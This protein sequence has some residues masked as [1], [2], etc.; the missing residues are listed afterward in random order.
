MNA[1]LFFCTEF[2]NE[3]GMKKAR[4]AELLCKSNF[5]FLRGASHPHELINEAAA[6]GYT[7]L[8]LNDIGG[9]Y[10]IPKAFQAQRAHSQL[11]LITGAE[12]PMAEGPA[13]TLLAQDRAGY[14]RLCR[15]ITRAHQDRPKG[16]ALLNTKS[17][18]SFANEHGLNGLFLIARP[19]D[20]SLDS[21][22]LLALYH[23]LFK[24]RVAIPLSRFFDGQDRE[25]HEQA[26]AQQKKFGWP[27]FA[28][29]DAHFHSS[30]RSRLQDVLTSI[31]EGIP[32]REA[33]FKL[34]MNAE[35]QLKSPAQMARI[36]S[37]FPESIE[38][39]LR[40]AETCTFSPAELR[41]R[42]P[43]EWIPT[44]HT[45]QSYLEQESRRGIKDLYANEVPADV[46]KQLNFELN[47][48][49]E[50]GFAD[51]FLS[52]YDIVCF[53]RTRQILCQG[54][55]SAANSVVCYALGITAID[56]VRMS[57]LFERFISVERGEPPD[58]DV[59]FEHERREEVIQYIYEKYGRDRAAMVSA[60]IT[61]RRRSAFREA[62]KALG[63]N[64]G[65]HSARSVEKNFAVLCPH[66]PTRELVTNLADEM[67]TFPRHLS[68][69]SGGFT[70]SA[71]PIIETV[72]VEP[73]AMQGRSIV[74]WDKYDL[75]ILGLLKIDVLALGML[76]ALRKTLDLTQKKLTDIPAD[77]PA[78]YAMIQKADT[79]GVFQI[80]SRAQ[81]NMLPRLLPKNFY[82][83]VIQV[84]IVRPGP[85]V[86]KMVHPYL[87]RRKGLEDAT[88]PDSRLEPILGRTLG[89][90]IFQEQI[91]KMAIHLGGFTPGEADQLRRAIG[92]WR[93]AGSIDEAGQRLRN[94]LLKNG[95]PADF[96]DRIFL[97]I[98]GFSEYGFPESHAA[99]FALLA[100]ASSYL[101]CHHPAEFACSLI[102][103]QPMGF[104]S[105]HSI[106]D[107]AK[108]HGVRT[109]AVNVNRSE[110]D[111]TIEAPN[112]I[113]LGLR[114]V[115][116]M[117]S[118]EAEKI[119]RARREKSF[120]DVDDFYARAPLKKSLLRCLAAGDA[121]SDFGHDRRHTLWNLLAAETLTP[122]PLAAQLSLFS[123]KTLSDPDNVTPQPLF[124][125]FNDYQHIKADYQS[126]GLSTRG[127]PM[128]AIR[129]HVEKLPPRRSSDLRE[130]KHGS[131]AEI[132][133]LVI[134]L[135]RPPTAKG[136][137]FGTLEDEKGFID[138]IIWK[139][140]FDRFRELILDHSLLIISGKIQREGQSISLL[141]SSVRRFSDP[142]LASVEHL[143]NGQE[144]LISEGLLAY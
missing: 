97:Q 77:D 26:Q 85:I 4:F 139:S 1:A 107:D 114:V 58:I 12:I 95:I 100:Y 130:Q 118:K 136:T 33:G 66:E 31:R 122:Q 88:L 76:S 108:R 82:D 129:K 8:A 120:S 135:Q 132:A 61:Y 25:R 69:H 36:F 46:A 133:G 86:G 125:A 3:R 123:G 96:A 111:C 38:A 18:D 39:G 116:G 45:A 56:P 84:A 68:I 43:S 9:V 143:S 92:A 115:Y 124:K 104:Y 55:G 21:S 29:N 42:Y 48:I 54:R 11:K 22:P 144:R 121:L 7:A 44:G 5:S 53:A 137:V 78:T 23:D 10:G 72:P 67:A 113:R 6:Q 91:M 75:D 16:Q 109:L 60:V 126:Y 105:N 50:L 52:V 98:Q 13:L 101:K 112:T 131:T 90:P 41:Y 73:A 81:M 34:F 59:D 62:A 103:S 15:L 14:G 40:I 140:T 110:W 32:C 28:T 94:G 89:V 20:P 80:E 19:I 128:E 49:R 27:I 119:L 30:Q 142:Q 35:R 24:N 37:D 127:H 117:S 47:L 141:V 93:A 2:L 63:V 74:Q 70:L 65:A 106:L 71:D 57:L 99:S 51:Y 134:V 102:N 79:V 87:K 138:L 83:L 64:V 17:L